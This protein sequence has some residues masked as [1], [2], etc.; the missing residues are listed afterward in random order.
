MVYSGT[1]MNIYWNLKV[2]K[3]R[4]EEEEKKKKWM[5]VEGNVRRYLFI[6]LYIFFPLSSSIAFSSFHILSVSLPDSRTW[7]TRDEIPNDIY[8]CP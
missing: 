3:K 1:F 6:I 7:M 4:I 8:Y 2:E 5:C